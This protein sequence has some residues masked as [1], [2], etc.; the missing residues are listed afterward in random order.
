M[1]RVV[2]ALGVVE[3]LAGAV[4]HEL[5]V[6][7]VHLLVEVHDHLAE[8]VVRI[9]GPPLDDPHR[10]HDVGEIFDDLPGGALGARGLVSGT[11]IGDLHL[12]ATV[13]DLPLLDRVGTDQRRQDFSLADQLPAIVLDLPGVAVAV[14]GEEV[15]PGDGIGPGR[16][17]DAPNPTGRGHEEPRA[18]LG[19]PV[20]EAFAEAADAI[21]VVRFEHVHHLDTAQVLGVVDGATVPADERLRLEP[22]LDALEF[23][24]LRNSVERERRPAAVAHEARRAEVPCD[25]AARLRVGGIDLRER[26]TEEE[27]RHRARLLVHQPAGFGVEIVLAGVGGTRLPEGIRVVAAKAVRIDGDDAELV[28][29]LTH[30]TQN[31]FRQQLLAELPVVLLQ[32]PRLLGGRCRRRRRLVFGMGER[33]RRGDPERD[34]S[35]AKYAHRRPPPAAACGRKRIAPT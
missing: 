21:D 12:P 2:A 5:P 22:Q 26:K 4:V 14:V 28:V 8:V 17:V 7:P 13:A 23:A 19:V 9:F 16:G 10:T 20:V 31:C 11:Q 18:V 1:R 35:A 15:E 32:H 34:E 25:L 33:R 24:V 3:V 30:A 27:G 29:A 6:D